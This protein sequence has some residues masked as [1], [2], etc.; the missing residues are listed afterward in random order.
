NR[1][2]LTGNNTAK[3]LG[4]LAAALRSVGR[5]RHAALVL[6]TFVPLAEADYFNAEILRSRLEAFADRRRL[7]GNNAA[8]CLSTLAEA[9]HSVGRPRQAVLLLEA[10]VPLAEADYADAE[11]LR[12]RLNVLVNRRELG[13]N[14]AVSCV[15][16]LA[17][18]LCATGQPRQAARVLE[19]F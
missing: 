7:T 14:N 12:S 3:Y 5:Q 9:L 10:F 16:T 15:G 18:A 2:Q 11:T 17:S 1:R 8:N 19:A 6:E 13:G 4:T